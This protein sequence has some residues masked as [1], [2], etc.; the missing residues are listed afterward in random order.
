MNAAFMPNRPPSVATLCGSIKPLFSGTDDYHEALVGALRDTGLALHSVEPGGWTLEHFGKLRR[1]V[2]AVRPDAIMMQY[3]TD[4]FAR[5]LL[6]HAFAMTQRQAPLI[7]T[8]H[9]FVL[10]HPLRK[11]SLA[12]LL[13][14]AA[15][16]VTTAQTEADCLCRWY[17]WLQRRV[18]VIPVGPTTPAR[19]WQ[20]PE[21]PAVVY[22]GQI[23]PNKGIEEF[24]AVQQRVKKARPN[25]VFQIIG[26]P[27]PIFASYFDKI[28]QQCN[29]HGIDLIVGLQADA[30]SDHLARASVALLP[31]PDGASLRRS[32]M[33]S[34]AGCGL[35]IVTLAGKDTPPELAAALD[36]AASEDDLVGM[37]VRYLSDPAA[38][39]AAHQQSRKLAAMMSW[40]RIAQRF[41]DVLGGVLADPRQPAM[42]VQGAA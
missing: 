20:Q 25:T 3:P 15:A 11:L 1:A 26:S 38:A 21:I 16:I 33:L 22:F 27:V 39:M 10:A 29:Q 8:L 12:L 7:V 4:A 37:V 41:L 17:P 30:V 13:A 36:L 14:R 6:P 35:P 9:E 28:M 34:A 32:S 2:H 18:S 24:I 5:S 42:M 40:E 23:R 31:F 19:Q